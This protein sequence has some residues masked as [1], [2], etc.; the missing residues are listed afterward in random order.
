VGLCPD[1]HVAHLAAEC[2]KEPIKEGYDVVEFGAVLAPF[3]VALPVEYW[4][5]VELRAE[6]GEVITSPFEADQIPSSFH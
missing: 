2:R 3:F 5:I 1:L 4:P 6:A